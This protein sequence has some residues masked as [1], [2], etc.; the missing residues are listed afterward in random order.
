MQEKINEEQELD[1][2]Q[3][4]K[5]RREKLQELQEKGK[6]PF[7]IT[8]FNRNISAREIKRNFEEFEQKD[9]TI[10]GRIIAKRIMGK[11]SFCTIQD[12]NEKIQSYVSI[13]DLGEENYKEF[14]SYDIGDIIGITGFVFKT[15]TEEISVHAKEVTL[16]TKSLRP[17]PEKFHGLK[18][19]D[20]RYR[21]RYT[22]LI[23][24]PEVKNTFVL[25]SKIFKEIRNFMDK[26]GYMEVETPMLTTVA[27]GDA[28]RPFITHHNTLDLQMYLRIAPELNLK[29]LIVGGFDKVFEI[30]KNFRNEGMDI[31]HNP[32]FTNME[33][34]SAYED[35][36]DM[37]NMAES[38]ISTVAQNV[39][40]TTKISYQGTEID[41]APSWK[42]ITMIDAIK[43]VCG[44]DFNKIKTDEE[45]QK[46]A[47]EKGVE[48]EE[49]KKTR[50]HI[51]NEFFETFV[52]ETLIQPTFIMD[53]PV[54]ISPLTKRKK[55]SPE[56]VERFELFIGGREYGN[57]YS[58]LND[59]ID[60][61]ERFIK[62][63]E[64][65]EA[66]DEEAG[67]MDEDFVNALEIGL[68]PT[69]GMGIGLDRLV[70]LLTDSASIRDVLFFPTMKPIEN[71]NKV[72]NKNIDNSKNVDYSKGITRRKALEILEKYNK[73]EFHIRHALTVEGVM[74]Y[75]AKEQGE[76][77]EY[78]GNIGLLHDVDYE[79]YPEEHCKKCVELLE[80]DNVDGNIINSI[81]S[82]AYGTCS[83]IKPT[84]IMEKILF[85]TDELTGLIWAAAKMRPSKS[86]KDMEVSSLKKKFKDTKFAAGCSR[87][88]IKQGAEMLGWDLDKL[89]EKTI[90]AMR[91]CEDEINKYI[92][93]KYKYN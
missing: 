36:N 89:F 45:A 75:F 43:E 73:E 5:I 55:E 64:A 24:N 53:Y 3:L 8:K 92:D 13:N 78:W 27:T 6:N 44:V 38:L 32:E 48:Y 18:D 81:C 52:E 87:E 58:E 56:L 7:E 23:V 60:Q 35:Y 82:H 10:A 50:G 25:R 20:L 2:N 19:P 79:M 16:L 76:N 63:V 70:M 80:S 54:E 22:D 15:K 9:V 30:G 46:I 68:P 39:L 12:S 69:G 85:A 86:T 83:D 14:K 67:G 65:K 40:G 49:I 47:K 72:E 28:A 4:M 57:A 66:G 29:R 59:P 91:E 74:K 17:L 31:K 61:Y 37:M 90:L 21:Q 11:A 1:L 62:Q 84:H 51:I 77:E 71:K 41:L 93:I 42:R 26:N 34:Y 33:F 88:V